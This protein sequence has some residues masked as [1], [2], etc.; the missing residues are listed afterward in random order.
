[1]ILMCNINNEILIIL[2]MIMYI[3]NENNENYY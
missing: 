2:I 3:N 1:M